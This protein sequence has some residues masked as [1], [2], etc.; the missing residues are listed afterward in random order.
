VTNLILKQI[1]CVFLC[2]VL[3]EPFRDQIDRR[4][5]VDVSEEPVLSD[6]AGANV[7]EPE[8]SGGSLE[9]KASE[10]TLAVDPGL[11]SDSAV[12]VDLAATGAQPKQDVVAQGSIPASSKALVDKYCVTTCEVPIE[13]IVQGNNPRLV[14][15]SGVKVIQDAIQN[16]GWDE[17]SIFIVQ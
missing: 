7:R 9:S 5:E 15:Q 3:D 8:V 4:F 12:V 6:T 14:R 17:S 2:L 13:R 10:P 11:N 16:S 1:G